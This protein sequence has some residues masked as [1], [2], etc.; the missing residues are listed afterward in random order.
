MSPSQ[1]PLPQ[2]S[3]ID[4]NVR[5][6]QSC[7]A[8]YI[9]TVCH[10]S[11]LLN[12]TARTHGCLTDIA[13]RNRVLDGLQFASRPIRCDGLCQR[14]VFVFWSSECHLILYYPSNI[15]P[16]RPSH[17]SNAYGQHH[18]CQNSCMC[19]PHR[20]VYS[21]QMRIPSQK[22]GY[23]PHASCLGVFVASQWNDLNNEATKRQRLCKKS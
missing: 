12:S 15:A 5:C 6:F 8:V 1:S 17:S 9:M 22:I 2:P 3:G 4:E 14:P 7:P 16:R 11:V 10:S 20:R 19:I 13:N 21:G 23:I 18:P